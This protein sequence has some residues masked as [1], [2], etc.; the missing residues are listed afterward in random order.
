VPAPGL[1][2]TITGWPSSRDSA[3][4]TGRATA[5]AP[6]PGGKPITRRIGFSGQAWAPAI[7]ACTASA[8]PS[9]IFVFFIFV[10]LVG[11]RV[12]GCESGCVP[13]RWLRAR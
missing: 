5:S 4:A 6:P 11:E 3:S 8:R 13:V 2:S 7:A 10:S 9:A 12:I 1:F